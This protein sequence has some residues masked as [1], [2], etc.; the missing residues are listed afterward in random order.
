[1]TTGFIPLQIRAL[2]RASRDGLDPRTCQA[3]MFTQ[4][5]AALCNQ[6]NNELWVADAQELA[7]L[8][9]LG[10]SGTWEVI[11][12]AKE[13]AFICTHK[14][15]DSTVITVNPAVVNFIKETR[16][17]YSRNLVEFADKRMSKYPKRTLKTRRFMNLSKFKAVTRE[18]EKTNDIER[19][20]LKVAASALEE[21][22]T[23]EG[24]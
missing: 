19:L 6:N 22:D 24:E 4:L 14:Q 13:L 21:I 23:C 3:L 5:V 9:G 18:L 16:P 17:G 12:K 7:Q 1:M 2:V 11:S 15:D 10:M 8:T 20:H